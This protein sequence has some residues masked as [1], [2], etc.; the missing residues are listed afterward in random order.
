MANCT[1]SYNSQYCSDYHAREELKRRGVAIEKPNNPATVISSPQ[2]PKSS[3][4]CYIATA[5]Y[6]SPY[7]IEVDTFRYFRDTV[8]VKSCFGRAFI[9]F[10]YKTSPPL[11]D[12]I[13]D[14]EYLKA[15][16]RKWLLAPLLHFL[17]KK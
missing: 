7:A 12:F 5:A 14:R 4:P 17:H 11:A 16:T 9:A 3:S 2:A 10:Y 13:A 15:A 8:L 1:D 6:G